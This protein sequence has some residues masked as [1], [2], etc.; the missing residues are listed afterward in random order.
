MCEADKKV[1]VVFQIR[2]GGRI[3]GNFHKHEFVKVH[4]YMYCALC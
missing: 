3:E 4:V 1:K 2:G